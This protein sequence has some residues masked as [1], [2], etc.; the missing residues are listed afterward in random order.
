MTPTEAPISVII[1]AFNREQYLGE[2]IRSALEQTLPPGEIIVV[3]DGS[4]DGTAAVA[5]SFGGIVRCL[6]QKNQG[7]GPARNW[8]VESARG[9]WLAFLDSD[10][11]WLPEK[12]EWQIRHLGT[13]PATDL[14]FG[15]RQSFISPELLHS[16]DLKVDTTI[17][18]SIYSSCLMLRKD[19]FEKVGPFDPKERVTE[20]VEWFS[21][22][23]EMGC[24]NFV[25]PQLLCKRRVHLHNTVRDRAHMNR[26]YTRVLKTIL[27]RRRGQ[28]PAS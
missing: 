22:A 1:P 13:H 25:L 23:Q 3:D 17:Q 2:A 19:T 16:L 24:T 27:D 26:Q 6:S 11:L 5:R 4:T 21:R 7:A 28:L 20:F 10:D 18:P 9:P 8:G 15:H 14:V 12:L